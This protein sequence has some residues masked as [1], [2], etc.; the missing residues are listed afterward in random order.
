MN[1]LLEVAVAAHGGL[2]RWNQVKSITVGASITGALWS[3][4]G[5]DDALKGRSLRGGHPAGAA[6]D[7]LRWRAVWT[8]LSAGPR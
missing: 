3:L 8:V 7:G 1:D 6:D 4:K 5:Q 2:D